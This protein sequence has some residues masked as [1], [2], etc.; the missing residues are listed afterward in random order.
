[1][2]GIYAEAL[3]P[4]LCLQGLCSHPELHKFLHRG[5]GATHHSLMS[6]QE[7]LA[8]Y[9]TSLGLHSSL[10]A[11]A[12]APS[13][14][15]PPD[16]AA[17]FALRRGPPP[18]DIHHE[19]AG[20]VGR[21]AGEAAA[22]AAASLGAAA[23]A[24][25]NAYWAGGRGRGQAGGRAAAGGRGS[26]PG[27][28]DP[29]A[30]RQSA[31]AVLAAAGSAAA[32]GLVAYTGASAALNP[33]PNPNPDQSAAESRSSAGAGDGTR[34]NLGAT[35]GATVGAALW[36]YV[37]QQVQGAEGPAGSSGAVAWHDPSVPGLGVARGDN[38]GG[39]RGVG[40]GSV[41]Q[42]SDRAGPRVG[43]R[44]MRSDQGRADANEL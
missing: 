3:V 16:P 31:A 42:G 6:Y 13:A 7:R 41:L 33:N 28:G 19:L 2:Y 23:Y 1:M 38:G 22:S 30:A 36:Q 25:I 14:A 40:G 11:S 5:G 35:V 21:A 9:L 20:H 15:H 12:A 26:G 44:R 17:L 8:A 32:R 4:D 18:G 43:Q 37:R 10:S 39:R 34:G 27:P 29:P 24:S